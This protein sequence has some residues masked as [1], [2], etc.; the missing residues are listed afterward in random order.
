MTR[1]AREATVH[2][3]GS[4]GHA[5]RLRS[6]YSRARSFYEKSLLLRR[7]MGELHAI[8][9]S[10]EDFAGLAVRQQQWERGAKRLGAAAAICARIGS[11]PP[12]AW[13]DE[14][15]RAVTEARD[16]LGEEAFTAAL[17]EGRTMTGEQSIAY[18]LG[19][20]AAA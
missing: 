18:T 7:E 2:L 14:S 10:L 15:E 1:R 6:D 5:A 11:S 4:V 12:V 9:Q 13:R 19:E 8:A 17:A 3:L 20:A 16:V